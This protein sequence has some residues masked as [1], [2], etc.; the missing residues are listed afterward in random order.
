MG[1]SRIQK[2]LGILLHYAAS[3]LQSTRIPGEGQHRLAPGLLIVG[4]GDR[5]Q[6]DDVA[7]LLSLATVEICVKSSILLCHKVLTRL[8]SLIAQASPYDLFYF[9][10]MY[11]DTRSEFHSSCVLSLLFS[12]KR[13]RLRIQLCPERMQRTRYLPRAGQSDG[14]TA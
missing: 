8:I 6:K 14:S 1:G 2:Y 7:A 12:P 3:H 11:I 4:R 13:C 5:I 9:A 10:I